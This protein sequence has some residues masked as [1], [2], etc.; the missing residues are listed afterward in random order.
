MEVKCMKFFL[1]DPHVNSLPDSKGPQS[2]DS[3]EQ[4]AESVDQNGHNSSE[5][6]SN[7]NVNGQV[8]E[9]SNDTAEQMIIA[10]AGMQVQFEWKPSGRKNQTVLYTT[11]EK[12]RYKKNKYSSR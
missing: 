10:Q 1:F 7:G 6:P 5:E 4:M 12:Q 11:A 2:N 9:E 3:A 8:Y